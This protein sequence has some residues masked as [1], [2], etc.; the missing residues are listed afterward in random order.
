MLDS[1]RCLTALVLFCCGALP[2][3]P[4]ASG[5]PSP[6]ELA[7]L[8]FKDPD[9]MGMRVSPD[10]RHIAY[11]RHYRGKRS[12]FQY[13]IAGQRVLGG[14]TV[15]TGEDIDSFH[16]IDKDTVV[17]TVS[18]WNYYYVD[19]QSF[20]V[21]RRNP[22]SMRFLAD[23]DMVLRRVVHPLPQ[24]E[25]RFVATLERA[26]FR[27]ALDLYMVDLN[28]RTFTRI[29]RNT[30]HIQD[31]FCDSEGNLI[32]VNEVRED[33]SYY[34][35]YDAETET[36]GDDYEFPVGTIPLG[37]SANGAFLLVNVRNDGGFFGIGAWDIQKERL[38]SAPFHLDG[39]DINDSIIYHNHLHS[40]IGV[41]YH[42][43]KPHTLW[44]DPQMQRIFDAISSGVEDF[45]VDF[46]GF[47]EQLSQL[48][49]G[50]YSDRRS[51]VFMV[52]DISA[53]TRTVLGPR[54]SALANRSFAPVEPIRFTNRDGLTIHG[55]LTTPEGLEGPSPVV[56]LIHG[57]PWVRDTW[58]F[59]LEVQYYAALG[60]RVLQINYRGSSGYG[61][62]ISALPFADILEMSPLD[63]I[64]GTRWLVE[65]ELA[66]PE[67]IA[68]VGFSF[69]G[70]LAM[71]VAS[72]APDL[73]SVVVAS[74][75]VYDWVAQFREDSRG[76]HSWVGNMYAD[77][78]E[79]EADYR[80]ASPIHR[81]ADIEAAVYLFHGRADLRISS[82]QASA[83]RRALR[84]AG[85][86]PKYDVRN[87]GSHGFPVESDRIRYYTAIG[88]F[89][90]EHLRR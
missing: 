61:R 7:S 75:G 82:S 19:A 24:E 1:V 16:W 73:Y 18:R 8:L 51:P 53:N 12:L 39:F 52:H 71:E 40:P 42:A 34:R 85:N 59:D 44:F 64:D 21:G 56:V 23:E 79:R 57:G 60:F 33:L 58:T 47:G 90:N 84:R 77:F 55:Y 41:R 4:G 9:F 31:W 32:G 80:E 86:S 14:A 46:V 37:L 81:A 68:A 15:E 67:K 83:M 66:D 2:T 49:L 6:E 76:R 10:G 88:E 50:F 22:E 78:A 65:R 27:G 74:G 25:G 20:T 17:Y 30:G 48:V 43:E 63:V 38:S 70:Y 35:P 89:L 28:R 69:G 45:H 26:G 36:F 87:W 72:R 5:K 54:H 11:M 29:A 13:D 3:L 62:R